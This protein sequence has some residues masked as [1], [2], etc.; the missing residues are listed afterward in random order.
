MPEAQTTP[1]TSVIY[2]LILLISLVQKVIGL[3]PSPSCS[4]LVLPLLGW[5]LF[6]GVF[7]QFLPPRALD[8]ELGDL[9]SRAPP[10]QCPWPE[11]PAFAWLGPAQTE[12]PTWIHTQPRS[13]QNTI[14]LSVTPF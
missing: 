1:L 9:G 12:Q 7:L 3:S 14:P 8:Q 11:G 5:T 2:T 4:P 10:L 6:L 13:A